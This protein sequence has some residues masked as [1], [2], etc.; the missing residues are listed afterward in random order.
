MCAGIIRVTSDRTLEWKGRVY[1]C[2]VGA[3]GIRVG[4]REGDL[5]TP[6]GC[7]PLR[8]LLYRP[9]RESVPESRLPAAPIGRDDGWCDAPADARYNLAVAL[10]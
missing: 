6:V 9:D 10:P 2:A 3:G 5:A 1:P 4:K 7:F 8:R